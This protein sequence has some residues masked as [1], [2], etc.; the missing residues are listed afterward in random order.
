MLSYAVL[1]QY[2]QFDEFDRHLRSVCNQAKS[3]VIDPT[4]VTTFHGQSL[5]HTRDDSK[6]DAA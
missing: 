6:K 5:N 1:V 3:F 4:Y 2:L